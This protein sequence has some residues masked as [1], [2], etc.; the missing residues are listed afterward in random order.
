MGAAEDEREAEREARREDVRPDVPRLLRALRVVDVD[1]LESALRVAWVLSLV[2]LKERLHRRVVGFGERLVR[3]RVERIDG[4]TADHPHGRSAGARRPPR[5]QVDTRHVEERRIR[6]HKRAAK[7]VVH[8]EQ[9]ARHDPC[10]LVAERA[11]ACEAQEA[12]VLDE[13]DDR[14][15]RLAQDHLARAAREEADVLAGVERLCDRPPRRVDHP[16][17]RGHVADCR[18]KLAERALRDAKLTEEFGSRLQR[19]EDG[20]RITAVWM[21]AIH[22]RRLRRFHHRVRVGDDELLTCGDGPER[23]HAAL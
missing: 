3:R 11:S 15:E 16:A 8:A 18:D 7:R 22:A 10:W 13:R 6:A 9:K 14:A 2:L 17:E 4:R 23:S 20:H 21:E 5:G 12:S 19:G 1:N